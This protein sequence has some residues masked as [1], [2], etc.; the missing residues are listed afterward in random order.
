MTDVV[1]LS[2][3]SGIEKKKKNYLDASANWLVF[4]TCGLDKQFSWE[5]HTTHDKAQMW[6]SLAVKL[7]PYAHPAVFWL[8][9]M[10]YMTIINYYGVK[11]VSGWKKMY[12]ES[13][14]K[15]HIQFMKQVGSS[16]L[17][18]SF[19]KSRI[20]NDLFW[21]R[22]RFSVNKQSWMRGGRWTDMP[23]MSYSILRNS[24]RTEMGGEWK[25]L[26]NCS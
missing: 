7:T 22:D 4:K 14:N 24:F 12:V 1:F 19:L 11:K 17:W 5:F 9:I 8:I 15:S 6:T 25:V 16:F 3:A 23:D 26:W 18:P 2:F 10:F 13:I 20:C 21:L